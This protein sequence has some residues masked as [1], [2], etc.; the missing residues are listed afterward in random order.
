MARAEGSMSC[1]VHPPLPDPLWRALRDLG[2]YALDAAAGELS[3]DI[4]LAG[5]RHRLREVEREM[6]EWLG[7]DDAA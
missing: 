1:R 4:A 3:P 5:I 2:L 6:A 7:P